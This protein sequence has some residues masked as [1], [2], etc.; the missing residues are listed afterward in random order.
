MKD[1]IKAIKVNYSSF[2]INLKYRIRKMIN[3]IFN[4]NYP[5]SDFVTIK[6]ENKKSPSKFTRT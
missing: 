4:R 3:K 5:D 1:T 6:V 2:S